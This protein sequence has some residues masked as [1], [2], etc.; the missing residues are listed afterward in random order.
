MEAEPGSS[1]ATTL[2]HDETESA[3]ASQ[4]TLTPCRAHG[5]FVMNSHRLQTSAEREMLQRKSNQRRYSRCTPLEFNTAMSGGEGG[6]TGLHP[7]TE[8]RE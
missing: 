4:R 7:K 8:T 1:L 2:Q 5:G 3:G 6:S